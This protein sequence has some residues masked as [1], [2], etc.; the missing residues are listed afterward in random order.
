MKI[1]QIRERITELKEEDFYCGLS[2][3][4]QDELKKLEEQLRNIENQPIE[5]EIVE[6]EENGEKDYDIFIPTHNDLTTN[7]SS[8]EYAFLTKLLSISNFNDIEQ[9]SGIDMEAYIYDNVL[10]PRL[11]ELKEE[12]VKVPSKNTLRK[13]MKTFENITIDGD[14]FHLMNTVNTPH[15]LC[16]QFKQSYQEKYFITIPSPMLREMHLALK[17]NPIKVYCVIARKLQINNKFTKFTREYICN[18]MGLE[19]NEANLNHISSYLRVLKKLGYIKIEYD[20]IKEKTDEGY[21]MKQLM[22]IRL[23]TYQEWYDITYKK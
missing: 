23:A 16:Y 21:Q 2:K 10:K 12:G 18:G 11:D 19:P 8:G 13:Y 17:D 15:G 20:W 4:Q 22:Y 7:L 3:L 14:S 5:E 6:E 1:E 9:R